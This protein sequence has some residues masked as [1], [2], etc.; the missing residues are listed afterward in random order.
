MWKLYLFVSAY[1]NCN[2]F[3]LVILA[4]YIPSKDIKWVCSICSI[5]G[6]AIQN[7][8]KSLIGVTVVIDIIILTADVR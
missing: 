8:N 3:I 4:D 5:T 6:V 2:S 1:N 7:N